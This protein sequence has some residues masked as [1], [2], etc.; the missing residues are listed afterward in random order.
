MGKP[1][2]GQKPKLPKLGK[3]QAIAMYGLMK[4]GRKK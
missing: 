2:K 1:K 3:K 4:G